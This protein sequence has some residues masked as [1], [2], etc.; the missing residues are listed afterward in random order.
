MQTTISNDGDIDALLSSITSLTPTITGTGDTKA[1]DEE[2]VRNA[3]H[4]DLL[5]S[6]YCTTIYGDFSV[7][8]ILE[9]KGKEKNCLSIEYR[10]SLDENLTELPTNDVTISGIGVNY[11]FAQ[12]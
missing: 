12:K 2:I 6:S 9:S 7:G 4:F 10:L 8:S 11:N 3:Y 5:D 1:A